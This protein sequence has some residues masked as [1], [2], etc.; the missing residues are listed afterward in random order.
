MDNLHFEKHIPILDTD[1]SSIDYLSENTSLPKQQLKQVMQKGAVWLTH[2]KSTQRLRR[3]KRKLSPG[4]ELH[5]YYNL[6]I[7]NTEPPKPT[8]ISDE[9]QYSIWIK[10]SGL[11]SQGS[12]FG[13]HCSI[14]RWV[15]MNL[16][17]ERPSFIVH[18]LDRAAT[19]LM[20]IAHSKR[21]ATK[22]SALFASRDIRKS[23]RALVQGQ[24]LTPNKPLTCRQPV[25]EKEAI[26]HIT[27]LH[28]CKKTHQTLIDIRID[29][30][31]KHQIRRH[32][33]GLGFAIVNDRLYGNKKDE[34]SDNDN[35]QLAAYQ[36][37]F[38]CPQTG[39]SK[40]YQL[41]SSQLPKGLVYPI[42]PD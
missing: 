19:G 29:T 30:G 31:R 11:L 37:E 18:R 21:M 40:S 42:P 6:Q 17:P 12:K 26:S 36:L 22:L 24:L 39:E 32:L 25:D 41:S 4:D 35:L 1:K 2:N 16:T 15:E 38:Q 14:G 5:I 13:D 7:L 8:L 20:L 9:V 3:V 33:S 23:Y 27:S 28:Y 10:P 34:L